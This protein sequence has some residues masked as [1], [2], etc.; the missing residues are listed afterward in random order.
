MLRQICT[1][2]LAHFIIMVDSFTKSQM[3]CQNKLEDLDSPQYR[4]HSTINTWK[5]DTIPDRYYH[6]NDFKLKAIPEHYL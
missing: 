5:M 1:V 3:N 2:D 4:S 6:G